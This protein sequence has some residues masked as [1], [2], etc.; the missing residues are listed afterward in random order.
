MLRL[1]LEMVLCVFVC[2]FFRF[3]CPGLVAKV[4]MGMAI[5]SGSDGINGEFIRM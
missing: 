4:E 1:R 3:G 5:K 2:V